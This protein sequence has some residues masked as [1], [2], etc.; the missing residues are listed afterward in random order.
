MIKKQKHHI[1]SAYLQR[2]VEFDTYLPNN[3]MGIEPLHLLLVNDG[4]DLAKMNLENQ[5][6]TLYE[7]RKIK[8]VLVVGITAGKERL[9]EYG[10][11]DYPDFKK[12]GSKAN[13]YTQFIIEELLPHLP[14]LV[15]YQING[16]KVISGF[17]LGGLTAFDIAWKH[18]DIFDST[19]VF[20]A[21]FWWRKKDLN[22][23]Y[24]EEDRIIHE[25]VRHTSSKPN[26]RFWLMTGTEDEVS[27]RN[28]NYIIDSIDD[29]IDVIKELL[30][31]GYHRPQDLSYMEMVGGK[32]DVETWAIAFPKFLEWTFA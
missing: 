4:Q 26:L 12:R 20:S 23:S 27:D 25:V 29:T 28:H 1:K 6:I 30:K 16:Q 15:P 3:Y 14:T 11:A 8:P 10:V 19:G 24:T 13:L 5:L 7:K 18:S 22:D 17:S 9:Q 21:S 31:K 2:T 32:H